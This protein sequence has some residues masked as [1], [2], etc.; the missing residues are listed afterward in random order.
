M[1][2]WAVPE[3]VYRGVC[4][5]QVGSRVRWYLGYFPVPDPRVVGLGG[6]RNMGGSSEA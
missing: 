4:L 5:Q 6:N 1:G 2:W 3:R